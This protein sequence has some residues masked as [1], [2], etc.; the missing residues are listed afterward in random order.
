M[1]YIYELPV[2]KGKPFLN[3]GGVV[4]A[5]VG[6]WSISGIQTYHSGQPYSFCCAS[7]PP[8][9][10]S[11]R[12]N[13]V[14][15]Q[16]FFTPQFLSGNYNPANVVILNKNAFSDP[17]SPA[18]IAAGGA[19]EFG[20]LGRTLSSVRSFFYTAEDFNILKRTQITE[21]TDILLQVS[22]LDAF[23][24]HI[25]DNRNGVDLNPNDANFGILN[26]A[27]TILG[28]RRIQLQLKFEF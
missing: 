7:G 28:P 5:I 27:S 20:D 3:K 11:V 2:G 17:N 6:G 4:N 25:F 26:P 8:P 18:R 16:A 19:Y 13:Y 24:R 23:N 21:R 9:Y 1:S 14:P 12:Y 15:G 10:G 22:F